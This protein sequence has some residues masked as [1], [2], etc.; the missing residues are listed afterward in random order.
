MSNA[1]LGE[2]GAAPPMRER[3]IFVLFAPVRR[4]VKC[5]SMRDAEDFWPD[6]PKVARRAIGEVMQ[7]RFTELELWPDTDGADGPPAPS[8]RHERDSETFVFEPLPALCECGSNAWVFTHIS[9]GLD[10]KACAR[11]AK[12]SKAIELA[13]QT[14][15]A[16]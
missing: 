10:A 1:N 13:Q 14:G 4:P 7:Q 3:V 9:T 12:C 16:A 5:H 6:M 15:G 2:S 8:V 11:C